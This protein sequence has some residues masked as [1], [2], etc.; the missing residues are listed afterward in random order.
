[1]ENLILDS[2]DFNYP[3]PLSLTTYVIHVYRQGFDFL[4]YAMKTL[5]EICKV[6]S[7]PPS[8]FLFLN[9]Q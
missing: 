7:N 9:N 3:E 8:F 1:M 6:P 4:L 5:N 2:G